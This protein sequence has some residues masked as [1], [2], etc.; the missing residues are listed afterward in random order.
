MKM[1]VIV[2]PHPVL[3]R[4]VISHYHIT[5]DQRHTCLVRPFM[6]QVVNDNPSKFS[7]ASVYLS[8]SMSRLLG[9]AIAT[10]C[11]E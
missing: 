6:W 11:V 5:V 4:I 3:R 1:L 10:T 8:W 2:L 9:W 7:P